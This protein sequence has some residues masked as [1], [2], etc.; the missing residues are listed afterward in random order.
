M[1]IPLNMD[2]LKRKSL[3]EHVHLLQLDLV[4]NKLLKPFSQADMFLLC[5]LLVDITPAVWAVLDLALLTR[6]ETQ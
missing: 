3:L 4:L 6:V 2:S 1:H 5:Q